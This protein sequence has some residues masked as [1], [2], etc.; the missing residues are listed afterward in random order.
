MNAE[1]ANALAQ[2]WIAAWNAHDLPRILSH[3]SDDFEMTSPYIAQITGEV[4]GTLRGKAAVG[5]YWQK[6]LE[7]FP[8][9]QFESQ[10]IFCSPS[11]VTLIYRS[12]RSGLAAEVFF[13]GDDGKIFKAVAHYAA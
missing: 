8:D 10:H 12:N 2:S 6:A 7:K 1:Q 4:S 3:Y 11:S 5:A 13:V 9:L